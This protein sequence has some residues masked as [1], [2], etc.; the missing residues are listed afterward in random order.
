MSSW[1]KHK[2]ILLLEAAAQI[3]RDRDTLVRR[4]LTTRSAHEVRED[5][6]RRLRQLAQVIE[7]APED[8]A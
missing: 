2:H 1:G 3:E 6:I 7:T 5:L 4:D 8:A